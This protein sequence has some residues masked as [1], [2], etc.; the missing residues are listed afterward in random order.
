MWWR[1]VKG[2]REWWWY[3]VGLV[4]E[5]LEGVR[6]WRVSVRGGCCRGGER[7]VDL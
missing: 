1:R 5:G 6:R 2:W 3:G 7:V 4:E